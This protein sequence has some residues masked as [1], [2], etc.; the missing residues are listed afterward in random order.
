MSIKSAIESKQFVNLVIPEI[1]ED[2]EENQESNS[3][4]Y[5]EDYQVEAI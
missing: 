1:E 5:V 3:L 2:M 4:L